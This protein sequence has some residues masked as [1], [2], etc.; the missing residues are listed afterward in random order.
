[1]RNVTSLNTTDRTMR[2][3]WIGLLWIGNCCCL[4]QAQQATEAKKVILF[5]IDG[6]HWEAPQKINMP[7]FNSLVK[8]G[9]YIQQS[10]MIIPHHP[11]IGDYSLYNSCSFPNPILHQ[12]TLFLNTANPLLQEVFSPREQTAFIVNTIAYSSVG[13]G[14]STAIMDDLLTDEEVVDYAVNLLE[15]QNPVFMRIHLQRAGQR[16]N[17]VSQ[18]TSDK[19]WCRNIF[20]PESPYITAVENADRVLGK[21][22]DY[23]KK[24]PEWKET[25]LIIT[26]DH[27]QSRIGWHPL[28]DE[29][30]WKTPLLFLGAGI[31]KNR[32]LSYF[33][34]TDLAPTIAG[35]LG[36]K[37]PSENGAAG[38]FVEEILARKDASAYHPPMYLKTINEQL[39]AYNF[40]RAE[41]MLASRE[42]AYFGNVVALLE[43]QTFIEPFY[44]Q[45][46]ILEWE[47]A[48]TI[49]HLIEANEQVLQRMR[50]LLKEDKSLPS[51]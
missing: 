24:T 5:M 23:L 21:L 30:S 48:G 36:R 26:S 43:N 8:E 18:A 32:Q 20:H 37:G 28:F 19:P 4:L 22:V 2:L 11:T 40:M 41:L 44:Y 15:T 50:T 29:D 9:T 46:R 17:D 12:G 33:E 14:F 51:R 3:L 31:A 42:N 6:L 39:K 25:V 16:G 47:Q 45:D 1:M 13:R 38:V 49:K 7:V 10:Y 35:L 27:G 34:H